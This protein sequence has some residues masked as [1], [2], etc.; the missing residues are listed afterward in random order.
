ML[1]LQIALSLLWGVSML[2]FARLI[3]LGATEG[4]YIEKIAMEGAAGLR[5][6]PRVGCPA[7]G[8]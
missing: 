8:P 1:G 6:L 4:R 2:F 7:A 3:V 5:R